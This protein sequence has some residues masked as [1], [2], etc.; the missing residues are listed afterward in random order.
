M[1]T[2]TIPAL[3][4]PAVSLL[5]LAYTNRFLAL[6]NL[7][8]GLSARYKSEHQENQLLQI[9]NLRQRIILI[10]NMQAF[11]ILSL[12][13]AVLSMMCIFMEYQTYGKLSFASALFFMLIS[14]GISFR[15]TLLSGNA[16]AFELKGIEKQ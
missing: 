6:A 3:L 14:L 16:L 15:E 12:I 10:R 1:I 11:G 5:M 9:Q 4:F 7:I 2:L 13:F 8:R